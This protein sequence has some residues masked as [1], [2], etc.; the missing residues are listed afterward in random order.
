MIICTDHHYR[1]SNGRYAYNPETADAVWKITERT[2][3]KTLPKY[4]VLVLVVGLPGSGKNTWL[5]DHAKDKRL[6]VD[7][8]FSRS[9][10][11]KPFVQAAKDL[12]KPVI[13]VWVDT[14]LEQCLAQNS[15]RDPDRRIP[16][17]RYDGWWA[18]LM[19][20]PP[21]TSEGF[22]AA[23]RITSHDNVGMECHEVPAYDGAQGTQD[24]SARRDDLLLYP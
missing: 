13:A 7:A 4:D 8:T 16:E 19:E 24:P 15:E 11:R 17:E 12:G 3:R 5:V 22:D 6:Y 2:V 10:W 9:E 21:S 20:S 14:P 18:S 23:W 1:D